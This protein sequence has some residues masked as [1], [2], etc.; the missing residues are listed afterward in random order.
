MPISVKTVVLR[1][2]Y[3]Q[4][5]DFV[6]FAYDI[7]PSA[8]VSIHGLI[9]RG[10]AHENREQIAVQ[11]KDI[12]PYVEEALDEAIKREKNLGVFTIPSCAIDPAY[13]QY[14]GKNWKNM[15]KEMVY[16]SPETTIFGNL[17]VA[18][19]EYCSSC[20]VNENCSWA[21]ESAWKEY[22]NMFGTNE[23]NRVATSQLRHE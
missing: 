19:P 13:W 2:N 4:L 14:L 3:R 10:I 23:L 9:M 22:I 7:F 15:T 20:L 17:D 21:W 18:P 6:R 12:K 16:I 5:A 8:W 11:Y 1:Q